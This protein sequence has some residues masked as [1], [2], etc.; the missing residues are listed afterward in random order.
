MAAVAALLFL[1]AACHVAFAAEQPPPGDNRTEDFDVIARSADAFNASGSICSIN[2]GKILAGDWI[3]RVTDG[4]I[5]EFEVNFTAA[6]IDGESRHDY[7]VKNFEINAVVP[8]LLDDEGAT[9]P[10]TADVKR[11]GDVIWH[12]VQPYVTIARLNTIKIT[13]EDERVISELGS[14]PIYGIVYSLE[15][16][17]PAPP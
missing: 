1:Q 14:E 17:P 11:D 10:V 13:L 15:I 9:F 5:T 6:S 4:N 8:V 2:G 3:L 16:R 12:N 7:S